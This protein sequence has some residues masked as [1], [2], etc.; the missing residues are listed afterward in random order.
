MKE[1]KDRTWI[2]GLFVFILLL[3]GIPWLLIIEEATKAE[4][5]CKY[6]GF[7]GS[8]DIASSFKKV[9][10]DGKIMDYAPENKCLKENKWGMCIDS[11]TVW[12][13]K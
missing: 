10:C 4:E 8:T 1:E 9:E 11:R 2:L 6:Y 7:N 3:F 13:A 5:M 12:R